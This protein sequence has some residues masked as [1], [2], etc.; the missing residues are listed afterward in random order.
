VYLITPTI[1]LPIGFEFYQPDS[2][3][4]EWEKNDK[5]LRKQGIK[6]SER[7]TKPERNPNY[8]TKPELMLK[9]L[10]TFKYYHPTIRIKAILGDA[11]YGSAWFMNQAT[12]VFSQTQVISQ[13]HKT[14]LVFYRNREMSVSD[15]FA[16]YQGVEVTIR[17]RGIDVK[18]T[19][20]SARL[21]VRAHERFVIALKYE[22]EQDYRYLV[23]S[24]MSW[25][26]VDIASAYTL[27]W[28]IE[29]FFEDWKL[30][31]G[32]GR[33]ALQP[34]EEGSSGSLILS[35]LSDYALFLHPEQSARIK[36]NLPAYTVGSLIRKSQMDALIGFMRGIADAEDPHKALDDIVVVAKQIFSLQKSSKLMSSRDLGRATPSLKYQA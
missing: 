25:R 34:D 22:G 17:I 26:A 12:D 15:Y 14:Q 21:Y 16:S 18:V 35:L 28:L 8:P 7:P 3:L 19:L 2:A 11:L 36:D 20:G 4:V 1:S 5:K 13:L 6:K 9:L 24:D 30:Y 10:K 23:A 32:W 29:V 31:E 33:F 27:R